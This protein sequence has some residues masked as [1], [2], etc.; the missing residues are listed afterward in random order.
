MVAEWM[1]VAISNNLGHPFDSPCQLIRS[2]FGL[3]DDYDRCEQYR[4]LS[5]EQ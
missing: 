1:A 5:G 3:F 4:E 2:D